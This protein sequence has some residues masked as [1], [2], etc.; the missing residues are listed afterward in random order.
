MAD[1]Y[2]GIDQSYSGFGITFLYKG[3]EHSTSCKK[4][5]PK[6]VGPG[7]TRLSAMRQWLQEELIA[8]DRHETIEH[9]CMEGYAPGAKFGREKA[10][11]L[12]GMVK[13][14]IYDLPFDDPSAAYPTIVAP[15]S[16]KKFVLGVGKG[17]KNEMLLGCYKRWGM[18]FKDDN[19][20]DS[21]GLAKIAQALA[22]G[23]TQFKYEEEVLAKLTKHT[24]SY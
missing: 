17:G 15:T 4:F 16:L 20:A 13:L 14:A 18:D 23:K 22:T 1:M 10:G 2:I 6:K 3:G 9:I 21:F 11:E 8:R 12:G 24:E 5:D 19:E 7:V